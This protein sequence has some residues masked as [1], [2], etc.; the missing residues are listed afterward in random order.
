MNYFYIYVLIGIAFL[1]Q[2]V[3]GFIQ[4]RNFLKIF[5]RMNKKGKVLIGK[6]PKKLRAGSLL[7][8]NID[9]NATI[10]DAQLMKGTTVFAR[11]RQLSSLKKKSLPLLASSY[12]QLQEMDPLVK[13]CILNAYKEYINFKT[14]KQAEMETGT[15]FLALPV[16]NNWIMVLKNKF[17]SIVNSV[18]GDKNGI[19]Y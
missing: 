10:Q 11:F 8:L 4:L 18:K 7:L 3:F 12:D 5:K 19:Y 13:G 2:S 16:F 9:E 1:L 14:G 6:N 17:K 15:S